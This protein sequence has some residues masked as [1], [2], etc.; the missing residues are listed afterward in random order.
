MPKYL[1]PIN[2]VFNEL[3]N[4][5]I[6]NLSAD[7][8]SSAG[9]LKGGIFY[10]TT[11]D[12]LKVNIGTFASPNW[13]TLTTGADTGNAY[14][15][16]VG[17][18]GGT[19]SASL[20]NDTIAF[21]SGNSALTCVVTDPSYDTVTF[22]VVPGNIPHNNLG[23]LTTGDPHTQ[24]AFL[25]GRTGGQVLQGGTAATDNLTIK[26]T[27][28]VTNS[29]SVIIN[30]AVSVST[31]AV[32][33]TDGINYVLGTTTGTKFGTANN[34]KIGFFNATPIVQP[35]STTDLRAAL[36][37]LGLYTTGGATP[38][39]LNGGTLTVPTIQA[40]TTAGSSLTINATSGTAGGAINLN[41]GSSSSGIGGGINLNPGLS[42]SGN[43]G[44]VIAQGGATSGTG[45]NIGGG[46]QLI[47][48]A[49]GSAG[50]GGSITMRGGAGPG[51]AGGVTITDSA[52]NIKV[53]VNDTG[54]GFFAVA[55]VVR[56]TSTTD[57]RVALINLGLYTGGG[58]TPLDLNGGNFTTTGTVTASSFIGAFS[59]T[60]AVGTQA[61][62]TITFTARTDVG[63]YSPAANA[64]AIVSNNVERVRYNATGV[65]WFGTTPAAQQ[66]GN[67]AAALVNYGLMST[68]TQLLFNTGGLI[69]TDSINAASGTPGS[70]LTLTGGSSGGASNAGG[71]VTIIGG[72][73]TGTTANGGSVNIK[74]GGGTSAG[75]GVNL[76]TSAGLNV[77]QVN[78][79]GLG[80]Y[81]ASPVT[82]RAADIVAGLVALGLFS[83]ASS[84]VFAAGGSVT[85]DTLQ[86]FGGV[87]GSNLSLTAGNS[88]G[89]STAGGSINISAGA[90]GGATSNGGSITIKPG[91]ANGAT[92]GSVNIQGSNTFTKIQVNATGLGFFGVTPVAQQSGDIGVALVN[93]GLMSTATS[94]SATS[95]TVTNLTIASSG[96]VT[97]SDGDNITLGTTTGTQIGTG[98]TQKLAFYGSSPIA[99]Q[100]NTVD[101]RTA[102]I[103]LG[104]FA[105]GGANPLNLNG[106]ALTAGA[107]S[108]SG[109]V[110]MGSNRI[111]G[112]A[113]PV[114][115]QD[116]ATKNYVDATA[117]GLDFKQS[118]RVGSTA[119]V[120]VTY[121]ATNGALARGQITA[122]PTT[123]DGITL[124]NGNRI[125]LKNQTAPAQ[126]GIWS[127]TSS[128]T[129][130]RATDFDQD[131]EVTAGAF[132]FVEEGTINAD[133]G[134]VLTTVNPITIGGASGTSLAFAQFSGAGSYT[135]GSGLTLTG[136][137]FSANTN[138]TLGT[139][140]TAGNIVL[141]G[142]A[143]AFHQL[144]SFGMVALTSTGVVAARTITGTTNRVSVTNGTGV[145]GNP[146]IDIDSAYVGQTTITTLG[147]ITTGT[148]TGTTIAVLNGGTGATTPAG[149]KTNLGFTTKFSQ[150]ITGNGVLTSFTVTHNLGTTD[151]QVQVQDSANSFETVYPNTRLTSANVATIIFG[152]APLNAVVYRVVVIG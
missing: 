13:T 90:G 145:S 8:G 49:G 129:W 48:G 125:L 74:G 44:S 84:L 72:A 144:S 149:A 104:F 3:Q 5:T 128:G 4:A 119:N 16:I 59:G 102:L 107:S 113:D 34:Q 55:P 116:A 50:Q 147:T 98:T 94:F 56:P 88:S 62:P 47:G 12:R 63:L 123:L 142:Q 41:G 139:T 31:T 130:D 150:D 136:T 77:V 11:A 75:G 79:T 32:T 39:D 95:L 42:S 2:L 70:A 51:G 126:N 73:G 18:D 103:N 29:G 117:T 152:V 105:S 111:T 7:P 52:S 24:Y 134:W 89:A 45:A 1:A 118:A 132:V 26:S 143:L 133:T 108:F 20:V 93:L 54:L 53:Q 109:A 65:G 114:N 122:A 19:T 91:T 151:V 64:V 96:S 110:A 28:N 67:I 85:S 35:S 99:Q 86:S 112:L 30:T 120:S 61:A 71:A 33:V 23:G 38:L 69:Q 36:I 15:T 87:T 140:I 131:A 106:G 68:T 9:P 97:I 135:A 121:T 46:V 76:Q 21:I 78:A 14:A 22:T 82:Q 115:P 40:V 17:G 25:A 141:T 10:N 146:T 57:L 138:S 137:S 60:F 43:G 100:A 127:V 83:S 66:S 101:I 58:A 6:Q 92:A 148:W 81:N 80:F 37:N 124:V 27:S